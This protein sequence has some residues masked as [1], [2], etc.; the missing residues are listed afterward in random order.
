MKKKET[1]ALDSTCSKELMAATDTLTILN[2]K[3]KIQII[4][5]LNYSGPLRFMDLQR[6]IKGIGS[7]MLSRELQDLETNLLVKRTVLNTRPMTVEYE[8]SPH[9]KSLERIINSMRLW[10]KAHRKKIAAR[11]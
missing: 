11:N 2:G 3:W 9:G 1:V 10:G 8:L 7:K 4:A 6:L 5:T